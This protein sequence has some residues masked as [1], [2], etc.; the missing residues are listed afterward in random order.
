M[1]RWVQLR[2]SLWQGKRKPQKFSAKIL[3]TTSFADERSSALLITFPS[4]QNSLVV[5]TSPPDRK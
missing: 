2:D 3:S 4:G 1:I 5:R